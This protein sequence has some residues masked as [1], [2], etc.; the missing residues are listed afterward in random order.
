MTLFRFYSFVRPRRK[1]LPK[2]HGKS[3]RRISE[4]SKLPVLE[5]LE[6]RLLLAHSHVLDDQSGPVDTRNQ[7]IEEVS[8]S[9]RQLYEAPNLAAKISDDLGTFTGDSRDGRVESELVADEV[10]KDASEANSNV[11]V[12]TSANHAPTC[13]VPSAGLVSWWSGDGNAED[14]AGTSNGTVQG[15]LT[16][17]PAYVGQAFS[18]DGVD[19]YVQVAAPALPTGNTA[20]TIELWFQTPK[21]LTA[22]TESSLVQYGTASPNRMFGLITSANSPGTLYFFGHNE[23]LAGTTTLQPDTRYHGA[24]TYDGSTVSLYLNGQLEATKTN[25]ALNTVIDGN[26]LT[27]GFRPDTSVLLSHGDR[28]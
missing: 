16:F 27:I 17:V 19:D 18:F 24:V 7:G 14:S 25:I 6:A 2:G 20:R 21:D 13:V 26:G 12:T 23:D 11:F 8:A 3:D 4:L 5:V 9:S 10:F 28:P 15:G 1:L 22:S